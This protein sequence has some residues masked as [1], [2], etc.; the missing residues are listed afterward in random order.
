M[1][2]EI[3][4]R[5]VE[6]MFDNQQFERGV[7]TTLGTLD[8]LK[9]S[10]KFDGAADGLEGI[11]NAVNRIDFSNVIS[12][13]AAAIAKFTV[14]SNM[15]T[16][17]QNQAEAMVK[18]L[19]IDPVKAGWSKYAD[20]TSSTQTI[21][22]ATAKD[23]ENEEEQIKVVTEQLAKLNWFTDETSYSLTDMTN[24][25]GKFTSNGVKLE[26]AVTAMEGIST[27]AAKSG[28]NVNEASRAMY[29]LSQ[30]LAT[31]SVKLIDWKSIENANMATAEF[32]EQVIDTA[33]E[34][35]TLIRGLDGTIYTLGD[36][37]VSVTNFN[38]HLKDEWFTSD[39]LLKVLNRYGSFTDKLQGYMDDL[40][41]ET[42]SQLL[43]LIDKFKEGMTDREFNDAVK[44]AGVS[45]E[46]LKEI[47]EDLGSAEYDLGRKSFRAAQEAK[48]FQEAIDATKDAVSTGW[49]NTFQLIFGNYLEAKKIWTRLA[50][51][52]WD[53]FAAPGE[54]R[55]GILKAW[56][57]GEGRT[58]LFK[59]IDNLWKPIIDSIHLFRDLKEEFFPEEELGKSLAKLTKRFENF[60]SKL[61]MNEE[62]VSRVSK[63]VFRLV[64]SVKNLVS[65]VGTLISKLSGTK[66]GGF[67]TKLTG[68]ILFKNKFGLL[69]T[70]LV[71]FSD[72][73]SIVFEK[74][75]SGFSKVANSK[76]GKWVDFFADKF[77]KLRVIF[78]GWWNHLAS[79]KLP[80]WA[81]NIV[82]WFTDLFA[83]VEEV[84]EVAD[85]VEENVD[86]IETAYK[87]IKDMV[88]EVIRG[89]W[90]N[91]ADRD[92][93]LWAAGYDNDRIQDVVNQVWTLSGA[94]KEGYEEILESYA[95]TSA[96]MEGATVAGDPKEQKKQARILLKTKKIVADLGE[97]MT[98]V[99]DAY[100]NGMGNEKKQKKVVLSL[101]KQS[102]LMTNLGDKE[103]PKT[104]L[105]LLSDAGHKFIE[106]LPSLLTKI[107][108][109][110]AKLK[111]K[112]TELGTAINNKLG[113][114]LTKV[115]NFYK[116]YEPD[117]KNF[118]TTLWEKIKNLGN[119]LKTNL[120][121]GWERVK[122]IFEGVSPV[123]EDFFKALL[124]FDLKGM[125]A[126]IVE[127]FTTI[128]S[129]IK[130]GVETALGLGEE[131]LEKIGGLFG[132]IFNTAMV[133][134]GGKEVENPEEEMGQLAWLGDIATELKTVAQTLTA[135]TEGAE[136]AVEG[137]NAGKIIETVQEYV[138][139][140]LGL[141]QTGASTVT[142]FRLGG[143]FKSLGNVG[144]SLGD[145][146][147]TLNG[148][149][150][151]KKD[152]WGNIKSIVKTGR[153][154][155][156]FEE[157]RD[158]LIGIAAVGFAV[159]AIGSLS[160]EAFDQGISAFERIID[161]LLKIVATLVGGEV[162]KVGIGALGKM[163]GTGGGESA[164]SSLKGVAKALLALAAACAVMFFAV[165]EFGQMAGENP[166]K[167]VAGIF[168]V[169][170][171]MGLLAKAV[172]LISKW[173]GSAI[174]LKGVAATLLALSF[175][176]GILYFAVLTIG[177]LPLDNVIQGVIAVVVMMLGLAGAMWLITK[178]SAGVTGGVKAAGTILAL[179]FALDLITIPIM[180][181]GKMNF[182][183]LVQ[184]IG[185]AVL[186]VLA[187]GGLFTAF[188]KLMELAGTSTFLGAIGGGAKIGLGV[189]AAVGVIV[190]G[191]GAVAGIDDALS[192]AT[193]GHWSLQNFADKVANVIKT[194][195][196]A[197]ADAADSMATAFKKCNKIDPKKVQ[198]LID[199]M[200]LATDIYS[201]TSTLDLLIE[202]A[203]GGEVTKTNQVKETIEAAAGAF[204]DLDLSKVSDE[205]IG[206]LNKLIPT[207]RSLTTLIEYAG[208]TY[209]AAG[210]ID[211]VAVL[212][213]ITQL[214]T[215][216]AGMDVER[217]TSL[218]TAIK[219]LK[220]LVSSALT[221][222]S[223]DNDLG[224]LLSEAFI[225]F[226]DYG[227][228]G[229]ADEFS[230]EYATL[231]YD[232]AIK[233]MA[234]GLQL[235]EEGHRGRI[236]FRG[237]KIVDWIAGAIN[238]KIQLVTD[239][240][241]NLMLGLRQGMNNGAG[242][243][244][245]AAEGIALKAADRMKRV[246][247]VRSP[248]R[249]TEEIGEYVSLG[250]ANGIL[251]QQGS[252]EKSA[253]SVTDGMRSVIA[254]AGEA[255]NDDL[256]PVISPVL[257][258]S[259]VS[260]GAGAIGGMFGNPMLNPSLS[261]ANAKAI[262][263]ESVDHNN[264]YS[265]TNSSGFYQQITA[266]IENVQ[267]EVSRL[268]G[269]MG[270]MQVV[271]D[272]GALVGS[273]APRMDN[274]LAQRVG[275][276]ARRN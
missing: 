88:L 154:R 236:E 37:E 221:S 276:A 29:N 200:S 87:S 150:F 173:G 19:T 112:M 122:T 9:K 186:A 2:R 153:K 125:G 69:T 222:D 18:S 151:L 191:L 246:L 24:N 64:N 159:V 263:M 38:E 40:N 267:N 131:G 217:L 158:V 197:L 253:L 157:L 95:N 241:Y 259:N 13:S 34:L 192:A 70:A 77:N 107:G 183:D 132:N 90:G 16:K 244:Y 193:G 176:I 223:E 97:A 227:L 202:W 260:R 105:Q 26:T 206:K 203:T 89:D 212:D 82:N 10:L 231:K 216:V 168:A 22:S 196:D 44:E 204:T 145:F 101:K 234:S 149:G 141:A 182:W 115:I 102:Q 252:V 162:S 103:P 169:G 49:M 137:L 72:K 268:S 117:I 138:S 17:I 48:T 251:N 79:L 98:T 161:G 51:E 187:L 6:M 71:A 20:I 46:R 255:L 209:Y 73:I 23:F 25:I 14:I 273:I 27:W 109:A 62:V 52:L 165:Y 47:L 144:K 106:K 84:A 208:D 65:P 181:L 5:I 250:L 76:I 160:P 266:A 86:R 15:V 32:K 7:K 220:D 119:V 1:S 211:L 143:M 59:A 93:A 8:K 60:T 121:T 178:A 179:A 110:A 174:Q 254:M 219:N 118:L 135:E 63:T 188:T 139:G 214:A 152:F 61:K 239:A 230:S 261:I 58:N 199:A 184:G 114:A 201:Y 210:S 225:N 130:S 133:L 262:T 147:D 256:G 205:N 4:E 12:G 274:A 128:G 55:N 275:H 92:N 111:I 272:G 180:M 258:L 247:M 270:N 57:A 56:I 42:T 21:M 243:V 224:N 271:M 226:V 242:A 127:F 245:A 170:V 215:T 257:D 66:L 166:G 50:N 142:I 11:Q 228:Q 189:T 30:A 177:A 45:A 120:G 240:G 164:A 33:V 195:G 94:W 171:V 68:L 124:N 265:D 113:A 96:L 163:L 213:G 91:G 99:T 269:V 148:G 28:A 3:D 83:P 232:E 134:F 78:I 75:S 41:F 264:G 249:V 35:G 172:S 233:A 108:A 39:V 146:I 156:M 126:A 81:Q 167:L 190:E 43:D 235:A 218:N 185:G 104:F 100:N 140:F 54:R 85:A 238:G 207:F 116:K 198:P 67:L 74:L 175:A 53:V 136:D 237:G 129:N 229:M 31:G 80:D 155:S 123:F 248:S 36:N 194:I